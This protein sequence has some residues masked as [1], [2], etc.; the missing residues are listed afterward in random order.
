M[1]FTLDVGLVFEGNMSEQQ[2]K[3]RSPGSCLNLSPSI[4]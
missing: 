4:F 3:L 2:S 1:G